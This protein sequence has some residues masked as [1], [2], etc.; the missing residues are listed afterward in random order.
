MHHRT[1][2]QSRAFWPM[3]AVFVLVMV[4][5]VVGGGPTEPVIRSVASPSDPF[6]TIAAHEETNAAARSVGRGLASP[7]LTLVV[8]A[9]VGGGF[10]ARSRH[11]R[12]G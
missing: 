9:A 10:Y 12:A 6:A 11:V 4:A 2:R 7:L 1:A 3:M 8:L 5:F